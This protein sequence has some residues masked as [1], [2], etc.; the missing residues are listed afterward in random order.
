MQCNATK[1]AYRGAAKKTKTAADSAQLLL[2]ATATLPLCSLSGYVGV[3]PAELAFVP[4]LLAALKSD[5]V[6]MASWESEKGDLFSDL[7]LLRCRRKTKTKDLAKNLESLRG[8]LRVRI[9]LGA[10]AARD[11][12][13]QHDLAINELPMYKVW[14]G[15]ATMLCPVSV[16]NSARIITY[17]FRDCDATLLTFDEDAYVEGAVPFRMYFDILKRTLES[18]TRSIYRGKCGD[19]SPYSHYY[20]NVSS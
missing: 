5:P 10:A 3:D 4:R 9:E 12:I 16:S 7:I 1:T 8:H 6:L 15:F 13:L 2:P 19:V 17:V 11:D 18:R 14:N 20:S